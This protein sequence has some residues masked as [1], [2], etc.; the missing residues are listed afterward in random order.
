MF[1]SSKSMDMVKSIGIGLAVGTA[2]AVAGSKMMTRSGRR[3]CRKSAAKCMKNVENML[4]SI[5]MMAK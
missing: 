3:A 5:S 2:A 4:D 1:A